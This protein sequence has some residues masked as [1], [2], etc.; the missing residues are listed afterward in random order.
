MPACGGSKGGNG[1]KA[2][3]PV[4]NV[5]SCLFP[6]QRLSRPG[7]GTAEIFSGLKNGRDGEMVLRLTSGLDSCTAE[8][9]EFL[10]CK[11]DLLPEKRR[12][13]FIKKSCPGLL[14]QD[15]PLEKSENRKFSGW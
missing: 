6:E 12:S 11:K 9:A 10:W 2:G 15:S 7:N 8:S 4:K 5:S 14:Q 1:R 13:S 3:V